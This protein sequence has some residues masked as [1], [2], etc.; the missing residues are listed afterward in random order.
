MEYLI[1]ICMSVTCG[2]IMNSRCEVNGTPLVKSS[3]KHSNKIATIKYKNGRA[4]TYSMGKYPRRSGV[5]IF[6]QLNQKRH[7]LLG[8]RA[9][10]KLVFCQI[11]QNLL[12]CCVAKPSDP[13][14]HDACLATFYNFEPPLK[15][16]IKS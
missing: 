12:F 11:Y 8:T 10:A 16:T 7:N 1:S 13:R 3:C 5:F 14:I 6:T 9:R 4:I 2:Y 15:V